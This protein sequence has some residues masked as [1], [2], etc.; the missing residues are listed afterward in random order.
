[1][2]DVKLLREAPTELAR[3]LDARRVAVFDD[4]PP[5]SA[6]WAAS[7]LPTCN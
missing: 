5:D 6:G 7:F 1:M 4:L 2:L 3:N